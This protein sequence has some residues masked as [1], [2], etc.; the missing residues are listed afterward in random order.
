MKKV[1]VIALVV[2]I[3][4]ASCAKPGPSPNANFSASKTKAKVWEEINFTDKTKG[5]SPPYSYEWDFNNDGK[6]D[7]TKENPTYTYPEPD[8]YTVSLKVTDAEGRIDSKTKKITITSSQAIYYQQ[9][10]YRKSYKPQEIETQTIGSFPSQSRLKDVPWISYEKSYCQSTSLQMIAYKHGLKPSIGYINFLMGF[11]YGAFFPGKQQAFNP[12]TDP[13]LGCRVAAPYLGLEMKYLTTNDS[14]TFLN[15]L[16]FYLSKG[17]PVQVQLNVAKLWDEKEVIP[18]SELLAGYDESGFYYFET[19]KKDRFLKKAKGK[20]VSDHVLVEAVSGINKE[21]KRPWKFQFTVFEK[22]KGKEDL[23]EIWMRNGKLLIGKKYRYAPI[24]KGAAGIEEFASDI[25]EEEEI[26]NMWAL[27][28]MS[29][30][31]LD[32]AKFLEKRFVGEKEIKE[33]AELLRKA[34]KCYDKALEIAKSDIESDEKAGRV[35]ELLTKGASL[36]EKAGK[37]FISKGKTLP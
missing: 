35:A 33:A 27:E 11:T 4:S 30:S 13:V 9:M 21:F 34:D 19:N 24:A 36:E 31:R 37:I 32:N 14:D 8:D 22:G 2:L 3:L 29:Y 7:S 26:K 12:Y 5:G 25:E 23:S 15:A 28:A 20:K 17:R 10:Y 1:V 16:R 18:H 6:V